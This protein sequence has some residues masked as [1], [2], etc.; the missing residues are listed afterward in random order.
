MKS[1]GITDAQI[2]QYDRDGFVT[3]DTPFTSRELDRAEAA[4]D[5]WARDG[6]T[7]YEDA[8]YVDVIQ[9]PFFEAVACDVLRSKSV[10]LWWSLSPIGRMPAPPPHP[11]PDEQWTGGSHVDIQ[12][13]LQDFEAT[14][15]RMRAELWFWLNDVPEHRGAMRI[16]PGSHRPIMAHWDAVL[17]PEQK[18]MLPR[19]HGLCPAPSNKSDRAYPEGIPDLEG[20]PWIQRQ[21]VPAVARRGQMLVLCSAGLHSAWQ[22]EDTVPRKSIGTSW[23]AAGVRCGLPRD[24]LASATRFLSALK[25]RLRPDR[26]HIVSGDFDWLFES[27]YE[28]KWPQTFLAG[29]AE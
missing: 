20:M 10:H 6:A 19:V 9:H 14:P 28:P 17:G 2:E 1:D 8:G 18:A 12:A 13:T 4:W 27:D 21:P 26:S 11:D 3:I 22:N 7:P 5:R 24:Q 16:L 23:V 29:Y 25:Q 15:R